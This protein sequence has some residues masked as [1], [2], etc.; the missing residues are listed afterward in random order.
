M[1][2]Q[3]HI[4]LIASMPAFFFAC[5][6]DPRGVP[7]A[8]T[9]EQPRFVELG[10]RLPDERAGPD[11]PNDAGDAWNASARLRGALGRMLDQV[12]QYGPDSNARLQANLRDLDELVSR[13]QG[14]LLDRGRHQRVELAFDRVERA[15][16][17]MDER[18]FAVGTYSPL[19]EKWTTVL[20]TYR[21]VRAAVR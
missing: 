1:W 14:T 15:V 12:R 13:L 8:V 5:Q 17:T 7:G 9:L 4:L 19:R 3:L 11:F 16:Q 10:R 21:G 6:A 20:E 2:G 18:M